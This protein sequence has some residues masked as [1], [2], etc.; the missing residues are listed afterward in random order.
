MYI[1]LE[2][3]MRKDVGFQQHL[4][5]YMDRVVALDELSQKHSQYID[6]YH[7]ALYQYVVQCHFNLANMTKYFWPAYPKSKPLSYADY[8]FA[9][10]MFDVHVGG[11]TVFRGSRQIS[12]TTSFACRQFMLAKMFKSFK[13][14]YITP[15]Y[16]QLE[17]Y[18]NK[19]REMEKANRFYRR[20]SHFDH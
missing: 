15:Q 19:F 5:T 18:Q 7:D 20:D 14:L 2:Y 17:T 12:K 11:Y 1:D 16:D 10:Q 9:Y 8:P 6:A 4:Q 13:S 3:K